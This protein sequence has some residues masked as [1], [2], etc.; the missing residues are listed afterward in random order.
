M[1]CLWTSK[2]GN[3]QYE[4]EKSYICI[5]GEIFPEAFGD[6][7]VTVRNEVRRFIYYMVIFSWMEIFIDFDA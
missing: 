2:S 1:S 5:E 6:R 7:S 4:C 3:Y